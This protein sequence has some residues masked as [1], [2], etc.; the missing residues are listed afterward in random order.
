MIWPDSLVEQPFVAPRHVVHR[1][2]VRV[3]WRPPVIDNQSAA[4]DCLCHMAV[5]LAVSVHGADHV[6]PAMGA[7]HHAILRAVLWRCPQRRGSPG[8]GLDVI[9]A[10]WLAGDSWPLLEHVPHFVERH[11]RVRLERGHPFPVKLVQ[12]FALLA[13]HRVF[14]RSRTRTPA[15]TIRSSPRTGSSTLPPHSRASTG[16][17]SSEKICICSSISLASKPPS[18]NQPRKQKSS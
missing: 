4:T 18:S 10:A 16:I 3:L 9:D 2:G 15:Q 12:R 17:T 7:E 8:I 11:L 14:L 13:R 6:A 5:G 1:T